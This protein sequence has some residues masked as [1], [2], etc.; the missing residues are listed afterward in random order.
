MPHDGTGPSMEGPLGR[1][2]LRRRGREFIRAGRTVVGRSP[3]LPAEYAKLIGEIVR[4]HRASVRRTLIA[5]LAIGVSSTVVATAALAAPLASAPRGYSIEYP[6]GDGTVDVGPL[7]LA[8]APDGS[9]FFSSFLQGTIGRFALPNS[10]S[11]FAIPST[12]SRPSAIA[13]GP[14]GNIWFAETAYDQIGRLS[15]NAAC[16][17]T[18][19]EFS[20]SGALGGGISGLASDGSHHLWFT[21]AG[22]DKVGSLD[23]AALQ[24]VPVCANKGVTSPA[25]V[26]PGAALDEYA[27]PQ[28]SGPNGLA[29]DHAG[30]VW[31]AQSVSNKI[32]KLDPTV[33]SSTPSFAYLTE[34]A[35]PTANANPLDVAIGVG[36]R[37][38]FSENDANR[39]G[40][41]AANS[42]AGGT[43]IT[44]FPMGATDLG[45]AGITAGPDGAL[46][47]AESTN[48]DGSIGRMT[49][50]GK[51]TNFATPPAGGALLADVA[52]NTDGSLWYTNYLTD[53]LGSMSTG[54]HPATT[55]ATATSVHVGAWSCKPAVWGVSPFRATTTWV[56]AGVD[57]NSSVTKLSA[58][59]VGKKFVCR[60]SAVLP[61]LGHQF[62]SSTSYTVTT[63]LTGSTYSAKAGAT[64]KP[65]VVTNAPRKVEVRI[66]RTNGKIAL[67]VAAKLHK[68]TNT[69]S[70]PL[71]V[72]KK[73]LGKGKY[74]VTVTGSGIGVA[75]SSALTVR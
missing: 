45:P 62:V 28:N 68:G 23:T 22:G 20:I 37:V 13:Y 71:K 42:A 10:V 38:W 34:W 49:T 60:T 12:T 63:L 24:A 66:V 25:V 72:G 59:S 43:P 51:L 15:L 52:I 44:E 31:I 55:S 40:E 73:A 14:D 67:K 53:A 4:I 61:G 11:Q 47:I 69:V 50:D 41:L 33:P 21:A 17:G 74:V 3:G 27:L 16:Y 18:V 26:S 36:N 48:V 7:Q 58:S 70:V 6:I 29:I 9:V 2:P 1:A 32:A 19:T 65:R 64:L 30:N 8:T 39:I 56:R 54:A 35:L 5:A 75:T 46:W 57:L